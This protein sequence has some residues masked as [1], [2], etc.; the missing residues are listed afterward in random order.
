ME[1]QTAA[2]VKLKLSALADGFRALTWPFCMNE[3]LIFL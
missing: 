1:R 3:F 2:V